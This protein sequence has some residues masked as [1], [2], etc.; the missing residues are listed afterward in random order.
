[1]E[2]TFLSI[3]LFAFV[4]LGI[5]SGMEGAFKPFVLSCFLLSPVDVA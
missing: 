3:V 5:S 1:M 2:F 4:C